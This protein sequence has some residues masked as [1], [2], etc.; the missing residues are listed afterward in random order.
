L[1]VLTTD[2]RLTLNEPPNS[3][4]EVRV[5]VEIGDDP[6]ELDAIADAVVRGCSIRYARITSL[7]GLIEAVQRHEQ[8]KL[9]PPHEERGEKWKPPSQ[10]S[11]DALTKLSI[12]GGEIVDDGVYWELD[13]RVTLKLRTHFD[14]VAA[15]SGTHFGGDADFAMTH[16]DGATAFSTARF[17]GSAWFLAAR[18][19]GRTY[20]DGAQFGG[21]AQFGETR[22]GGVAWFGNAQFGGIARFGQAQ[23]G[24]NA[25][26][27]RTHFG[28]NGE[29][30]GA[31]FGGDAGFGQA[32]FG[33]DAWFVEAH[34]G[35]EAWF[36]EAHFG[37]EA[38]FHEAHFGGD[39]GGDLRPC[40]LRTAKFAEAAVRVQRHN[41]RRQAREA[42]RKNPSSPTS[43][44]Q[45]MIRWLDRLSDLRAWL[46]KKPSSRWM[47]VVYDTI[48][49]T[50]PRSLWRA[51][52]YEFGW[53][54]VRALGQLQ[55]LNRVSIVAL[56]AVP[57]LA[58]LTA[59]LQDQFDEW[60][61]LGNS[62]ALAFFASVF[63]TLGLLL[64]QIFASDHIR[65]H[66]EDE[67]VDRQHQRYPEEAK[68]R[69]DGLRRAI[70]HLEEI[71]KRRPDRHPNFVS[72]HGDTIWIPP[73]DQIDWFEDWTAPPKEDEQ[74]DDK[75]S[76]EEDTQRAVEPAEVAKHT[77]SPQRM[78]MVPGAER[79][80][81][82]IEEGAKAEYWLKSREKV[83]MA[84]AS[85]ALYIIGICCL[86]VILWIQARAV[87]KAAGWWGEQEA[88]VKEAQTPGATHYP[89]G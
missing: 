88:V 81:I 53:S 12:F 57:V 3:L 13:I 19:G 73:R 4:K 30:G 42:R 34:F 76:S 23:F 40:F 71:A 41:D 63:I 69:D 46:A 26:F 38:W 89:E 54:T 80:R 82:T 52:R 9:A 70:E 62:L 55:I 75:K 36:P 84:W 7:R 35:G 60:P 87:S 64:Y 47:V 6:A 11:S 18:F 37:G 66:D 67:F 33:G 39:I 74:P 72:H 85:L 83:G 25:E 50:W 32:R 8:A 79:R 17:G 20:F 27:G 59:V 28:G 86:L 77:E 58:S 68:D 56:I 61:L 2:A 22:F 78:G 21:D 24:E 49:L 1:F 5:D 45:R 14:G 31:Q 43:L 10:V 48:I 15:F 29:F 44:R 65:K 16:F 51:L